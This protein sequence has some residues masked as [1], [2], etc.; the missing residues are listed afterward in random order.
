MNFSFHP[1]IDL[2]QRDLAR[3][4][5]IAAGGLPVARQWYDYNTARRIVSALKRDG[6]PGFYAKIVSDTRFGAEHRTL[7]LFRINSPEHYKSAGFA[8]VCG[9][10]ETLETAV[11]DTQCVA[12]GFVE[13][14]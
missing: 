9:A 14:L 5:A 1:S 3:A 4:Q 10:T 6:V 13:H 12:R 2:A 8:F 7:H 11:L